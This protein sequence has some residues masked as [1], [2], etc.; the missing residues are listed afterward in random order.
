M[1]K[2]KL[3]LNCRKLA[4]KFG[5]ALD[6]LPGIDGVPDKIFVKGSSAFFVEFSRLNKEGCPSENLKLEDKKQRFK[7]SNIYMVNDFELFRTILIA[8]DADHEQAVNARY[9]KMIEP[10]EVNYENIDDK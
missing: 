7:N 1:N 6:E 9:R 2:K 10:I 5:W 8:E 3:E 4:E